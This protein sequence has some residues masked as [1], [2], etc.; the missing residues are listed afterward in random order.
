MGW[1]YAMFGRDTAGYVTTKKVRNMTMY[2]RV[3][4]GREAVRDWRKYRKQR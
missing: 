3:V 1:K 4:T 2:V